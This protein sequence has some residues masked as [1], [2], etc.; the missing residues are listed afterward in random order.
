M[1]MHLF[2]LPATVLVIQTLA[3][4]SAVISCPATYAMNCTPCVDVHTKHSL[5]QMSKGIHREA[6]QSSFSRPEPRKS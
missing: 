3:T 6:S 1:N 5:T 2:Q 4:V